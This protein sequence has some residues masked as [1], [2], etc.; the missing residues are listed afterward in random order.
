[1]IRYFLTGL[2][3]KLLITNILNPTSYHTISFTNI[4]ENRKK[5]KIRG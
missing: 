1:M 3:I 5:N 4:N 2:L